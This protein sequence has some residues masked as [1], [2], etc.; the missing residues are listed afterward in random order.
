MTQVYRAT[1]KAI[2]KGV[3]DPDDRIILLG[4]GDAIWYRQSNGIYL[5]TIAY[6]KKDSHITEANESPPKSFK[7]GQRTIDYLTKNGI[8]T[9]M[10]TIG[11]ILEYDSTRN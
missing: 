1:N 8:V 5:D 10:N 3:M 9:K 7:V 2:K 4:D 6:R 11:I